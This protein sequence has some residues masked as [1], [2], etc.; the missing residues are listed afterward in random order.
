MT[1][2]VTKNIKVVEFIEKV[3]ELNFC[4]EP[5]DE[6]LFKITSAF[7]DSDYQIELTSHERRRYYH[8]YWRDPDE[9]PAV[10]E[11]IYTLNIYKKIIKEV[12]E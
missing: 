9:K 5:T 3:G 4:D 6:D 8:S 10:E 1:K 12:E 7:S 2:K 11:T